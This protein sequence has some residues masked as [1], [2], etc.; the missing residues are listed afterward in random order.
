[1]IAFAVTD[2]GIGI[3]GQAAA[4]LRGLPAGGRHDQPQVRRH[5]PGPL[6]LPRDRLAAGRRDPG[7]ER[8]GGGEHLHPLP[9]GALRGRA[10]CPPDRGRSRGG[11]PA[12]TPAC[13]RERRPCSGSG[14]LAP[15]AEE[16]FVVA[17]AGHAR[18]PQRHR[19]RRPRGPDHRERR[20]LRPRAARHGARQGVPGDRRARRRDRALAGPRVRCRTPS[21]STST[22]RASTGGRCSTG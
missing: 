9:P 20:Q 12:S 7:G 22:S 14:R 17:V 13:R 18:R 15:A 21:P 19:G 1:V 5:R 10:R 3:E 16:N 8:G 2:T 11:A 6:D 4:D